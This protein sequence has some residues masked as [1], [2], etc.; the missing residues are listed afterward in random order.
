MPRRLFDQNLGQSGLLL[1]AADGGD[2]KWGNSLNNVFGRWSTLFFCASAY[3]SLVSALED[4]SPMRGPMIWKL[5]WVGR[6]R[7]KNDTRHIQ[8]SWYHVLPCPKILQTAHVLFCSV[9]ISYQ[10]LRS[11]RVWGSRHKR[12]KEAPGPATN[13][14]RDKGWWMRLPILP[15]THTVGPWWAMYFGWF[16]SC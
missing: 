16:P 15:P 5:D 6:R 1:R 7:G 4:R 3:K 10:I 8:S 12:T 13:R 2:V 9:E 14:E 11:S